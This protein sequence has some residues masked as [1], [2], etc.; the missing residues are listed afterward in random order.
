M[1]AINHVIVRR[2][3]RAAIISAV[4]HE[5]CVMTD[6][7]AMNDKYVVVVSACWRVVRIK[8]GKGVRGDWKLVL[9]YR[10]LK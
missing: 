9:C 3:C 6:V 5:T 2:N 1:E 8:L 10:V 4:Y 7:R